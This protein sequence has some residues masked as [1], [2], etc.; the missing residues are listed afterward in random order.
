MSDQSTTIYRPSYGPGCLLQLLWF[1]F[2]GWW[3]GLWA[4]G[5][6]WLLNITIIGLPL[7]LLILNNIPMVIA[8]QSP[9]REI[10][11][12]TE[13][14]KTGGRGAQPRAAQLLPAGAVLHLHRLVVQPDLAADRLPAVR[15]DLPAAIRPADVPP[16][17][18]P[19][20]LEALLIEIGR[21]P[22]G[23]PMQACMGSSALR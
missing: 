14:G 16:D 11:A 6:A 18:V 17:A 15:H 5:I 3:L 9:K 8:L 7:G 4:I 20:H 22:P 13:D 21:H 23:D 2:I 1:I 12:V 19:D 10:R